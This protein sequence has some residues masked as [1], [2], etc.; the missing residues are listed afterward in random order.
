MIRG[1]NKYNKP[2]GCDVQ[3][4]KKNRNPILPS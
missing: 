3:K 1:I 2:I 4:T